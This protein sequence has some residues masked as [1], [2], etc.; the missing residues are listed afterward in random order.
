MY[1]KALE[2]PQFLKL[3]QSVSDVH[4]Y[5]TGHVHY[6]GQCFVNLP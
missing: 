2:L 1:A 6:V 4:T 5:N 3:G